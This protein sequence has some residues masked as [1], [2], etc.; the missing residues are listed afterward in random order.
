MTNTTR[1]V[2]IE[3]LSLAPAALLVAGVGA[4]AAQ[5]ASGMGGRCVVEG[6]DGLP[7]SLHFVEDSPHGPSRACRTCEFWSADANAQCGMC[8]MMR[9]S[10]PPTGHCDAWTLRP[11]SPQPQG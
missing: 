11:G 2:F 6:E 9:R 5:P 3:R 1:R 8:V 10:T 7:A 4:A